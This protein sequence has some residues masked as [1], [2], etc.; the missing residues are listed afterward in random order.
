MTP[1]FIDEGEH[2]ENSVNGGR[3]AGP[4]T[5]G[6][7]KRR[8]LVDYELPAGDARLGWDTDRVRRLFGEIE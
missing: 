6:N 2:P 5:Q 7:R 3:G 4:K 8:V 1:S